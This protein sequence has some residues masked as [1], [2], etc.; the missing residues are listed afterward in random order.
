[1]SQVL[2]QFNKI[3]Y[4]FILEVVTICLVINFIFAIFY[5]SIYKYDSSHFSTINSDHP[6]KKKRRLSLVDFFYFANTTFF[7]GATDIASKSILCRITVILHIIIGF[8]FSG[9]IIGKVI[10]IPK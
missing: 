4:L 3:P 5:Y 6:E 2:S 1:M 8:I 9:I 7:T 10:S